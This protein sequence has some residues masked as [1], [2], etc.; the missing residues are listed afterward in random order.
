MRS[1]GTGTGGTSIRIRY[2]GVLVFGC[3]LTGL[4]ACG[5]DGTTK[6]TGAVTFW[7][8]VA[9]I[10]NTKCVGCHQPGG[11]A[12]FRLD[13]YQDAKAFSSFEKVRVN[14][15]TMP[16]YFMVHDGSCGEFQDDATLTDQQKTTINAWIDGGTPEGTPATL[17]LP[18]KPV[19]A[20]ASD[21]ATPNFM[22]VAQG[23]QLAEFDEYRCFMVDWPYAGNG[24]LTGYDVTPGN[25]A[26]V[27][28]VLGFVVDPQAIGDGG[29]TNA[30]IIESLKDPGSPRAGWPCFGGAGDGV[31]SSG[32]PITWAPGQG[33]VSYPDGMGVPVHTTD[34]LVIQ[35]HY[36][37]ADPQSVGKMDS[38]TVHLRFASSVNRDIAF[39]LPDPFLESIA[40]K[41]SAGNPSPDTLPPG[42]ADAKYTWT[43]MA[44]DLGIDG[45]NIP[46]V[47][48]MAVMP[49][50]HGR[51]VSQLVKIGPA[52]NATCAANLQNWSF[53]WQEF[54]TYKTPIKIM[55]DTQI[56]V[57]CDYNTAQDTMP[58]LPGWGTR[59]EM[60]L[61]VLM[62]ALPAK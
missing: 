46:S 20:G 32:L 31:N 29:L 49:H 1:I 37:L 39:L 57:T 18:S 58:V 43:R 25:D 35:V 45:T 61:A 51:G 21:V 28:H 8:D 24:F 17:A 6:T 42:Q 59:N 11:I 7:Q 16:P 22:P 40:R 44:H 47:D 38:T 48:L 50:M 56:Q 62:V 34:K 3:L 52:G 55:P 36:N 26:I 19:L 4:G 60:C 30:A 10:Y 12:P 27:H 33:V 13:T 9:P 5:D 14:A 41:D 23:G 53:H 2:T 15:G 54:Y